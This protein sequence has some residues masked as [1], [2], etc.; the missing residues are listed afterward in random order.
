MVGKIMRIQRLPAYTLPE[1][2]TLVCLVKWAH[3]HSVARYKVV[4]VSITLTVV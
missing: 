2:T 3:L 1:V 4:G